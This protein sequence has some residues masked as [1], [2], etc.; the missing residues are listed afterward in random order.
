MCDPGGTLTV[1]GEH[2]WTASPAPFHWETPVESWRGN[3]GGGGVG[4]ALQPRHGAVHAHA[5]ALSH[6]RCLLRCAAPRL[7][8]QQMAAGQRQLHLV[9]RQRA[10]R[11]PGRGRRV[12]GASWATPTHGSRQPQH[13]KGTHLRGLQLRAHDPPIGVA[14]VGARRRIAVAYLLRNHPPHP[15]QTSAMPAKANPDSQGSSDRPRLAHCFLHGVPR[16]ATTA[17]AMRTESPPVS[18]AATRAALCLRP[19]L[20]C[21]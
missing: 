11:S 17:A 12:I 9:R 15:P 7:R 2:S 3:A 19:A 4:G 14:L 16:Q 13:A 10:L 5:A 6:R 18:A 21:C 1:P 8:F 20:L